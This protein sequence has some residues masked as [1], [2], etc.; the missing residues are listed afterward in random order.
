MG[1][2]LAIS[3]VIGS[4]DQRAA[5]WNRDANVFLTGYEAPRSDLW[6]PGDNEPARRSWD[7]VVI[8]EAQRIKNPKADASIAVKVELNRARSWALTGTPL[9]NRLND[10]ISVLDFAA[11]GHFDPGAMAVG[12]RRLLGEV[13]LGRCRRDVLPDLPPKFISTLTLDLTG[14]QRTAYRRAEEEGVVWLGS[15]GRN[16]VSA[17]C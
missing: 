17:M 5:A 13:Q 4:A 2:E 6:L 7:V 14:P 12:L 15:L 10:L 8:D 16:C 1:T 11:P 9:E 3:T